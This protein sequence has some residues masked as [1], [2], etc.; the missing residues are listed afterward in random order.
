MNRKNKAG[1]LK[2]IT[3]FVCAFLILNLIQVGSSVDPDGL[4][5]LSDWPELIFYAGQ[6]T[7]GKF[8]LMIIN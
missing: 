1:N 3:K 4:V 2:M 7:V 5:R 6:K 8:L